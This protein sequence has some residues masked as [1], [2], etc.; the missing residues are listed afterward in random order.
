ML[1]DFTLSINTLNNS[2]A[3]DKQWTHCQNIPECMARYTS[4]AG[5]QMAAH[6]SFG[7][8]AFSIF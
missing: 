2:M 3:S 7:L 6:E 1:M 4:P 5:W 8:Y